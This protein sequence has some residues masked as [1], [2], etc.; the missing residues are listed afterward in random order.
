MTRLTKITI[1]LAVLN[2]LLALANVIISVVVD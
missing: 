1:G 2:V